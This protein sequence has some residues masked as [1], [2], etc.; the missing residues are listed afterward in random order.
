MCSVVRIG[1]FWRHIGFPQGNRHDGKWLDPIR[2]GF[3]TPYIP[4][5][6]CCLSP[7]SRTMF[8]WPSVYSSLL[9][10]TIRGFGQHTLSRPTEL[11][12]NL[13]SISPLKH[14]Q[15]GYPRITRRAQHQDLHCCP[16]FFVVVCRPHQL[17]RCIVLCPDHQFFIACHGQSLGQNLFKAENCFG[18][19]MA[20]S[21]N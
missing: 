17:Q 3:R 7:V 14:L 13:R 18:G 8:I 2:L 19:S 9:G 21:G 11:L 10:Q 16:S 5:P 4:T 20:M 1:M 12:I 15:V 6:L